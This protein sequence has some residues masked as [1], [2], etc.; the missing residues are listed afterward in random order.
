MQT[1]SSQNTLRKVSSLLAQ[2]YFD[3]SAKPLFPSESDRSNVFNRVKQ[4]NSVGSIVLTDSL[5]QICPVD[6]PLDGRYTFKGAW[7]GDIMM[8]ILATSYWTLHKAL[9]NPSAL[10]HFHLPVTWRHHPFG[11]GAELSQASALHLLELAPP[12]AVHS[13]H[14]S[15]CFV[16]QPEVR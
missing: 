3:G 5:L 16:S 7:E 12:G 2:I 1:K 11:V 13:P 15:G 9:I 10:L 6:R 8:V 14:P 4:V